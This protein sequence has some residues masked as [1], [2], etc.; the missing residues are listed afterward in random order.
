MKRNK[1]LLIA[2]AAALG[3][4]AG[5]LVFEEEERC[6]VSVQEAEYNGYDTIPMRDKIGRMFV[7]GID[8]T[9]L[10]Q[11]D[12]II[13]K[14]QDMGVGGVVLFGYNIPVGDEEATSKEKLTKLCSDLQGLAD[15]GLMIGIDQEGGKVMRLRKGNGYEEMPS[16][17]Y[18]GRIDNEDTTRHYA[19]LTAGMLKE[20]GINVNFA[21]CVDVNVNP[22]CPVIGK[23]DRSFSTDSEKVREHASYFIDE[24]RR[25]GVS[26]AVKHFP[27]H[28][29]SVSD[30]HMGMTDVS[31]TWIENEL[32]PFMKLVRK[33]KCD[34]V[35]VGHL[36]NSRIDPLYPAS[37]SEA[38][39]ERLLRHDLG[40]DGVVIS[41]DIGMKAINSNYPLEESLRLCINAG[42]DMIMLIA[43]GTPERLRNAIDAVERMVCEGTIQ[44]DRINEAYGRID[45]LF[46]TEKE[47]PAK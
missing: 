6:D 20:I 1:I 44:E 21:P 25:H 28:G 2:V 17:A 18:L 31:G 7:V 27:G 34:M 5:A 40:W 8:S 37:L 32:V 45:R 29:S 4:A 43:N 30:S 33:E 26:T 19:G 11:D 24:H 23:A 3:L 39:V 16:H 14:I 47:R 41:D 22:S 38:T 35:M 13:G 42:V 36:F 9:A 12:P 15:Y 10:K 46:G